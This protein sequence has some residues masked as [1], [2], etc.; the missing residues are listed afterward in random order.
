MPKNPKR[1]VVFDY[2]A[3]DLMKA[4]G[5]QDTIKALPKGEG[6]SSVPQFYQ[7]L[8]MINTSTLVK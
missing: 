8:K 1:A 5:V 4:F 3:V 6:V 2:A 7:N